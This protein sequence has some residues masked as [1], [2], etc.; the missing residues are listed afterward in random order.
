[1]ALNQ[2]EGQQDG[3]GEESAPKP[4]GLSEGD[5]RPSWW[6]EGTSSYT[7]SSDLVSVG[8]IISINSK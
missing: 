7:L 5:P 1:M 8:I 3:G 6:E 2:P 4:E